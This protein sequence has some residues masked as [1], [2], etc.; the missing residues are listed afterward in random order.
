[1]SSS[2]FF[3]WKTNIHISVSQSITY[4]TIREKARSTPHYSHRPLGPSPATISIPSSIRF[5]DITPAAP[6]PINSYSPG[7]RHPE[8]RFEETKSDTLLTSTITTVSFCVALRL[9]CPKGQTGTSVWQ[10]GKFLLAFTHTR[11]YL[12][13]NSEQ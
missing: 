7:N 13:H 3:Y 12:F 2:S 10:I 6:S 5:L 11:P 8:S 1:M 9:L 4:C